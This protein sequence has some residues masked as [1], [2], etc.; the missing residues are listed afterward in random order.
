MI[1]I[2][3]PLMYFSGFNPR[4]SD[5]PVTNVAVKIDFEGFGSL[6]STTKY[7]GPRST[8]G[9][10]RVAIRQMYPSLDLN[11]YFYDRLYQFIETEKCSGDVWG[12]SPQGIESILNADVGGFNLNME[13][14]ITRTNSV[15]SDLLVSKIH[16]I[17]LDVENGQRLQNL[18]RYS[19]DLPFNATL[20]DSPPPP[21]RF[22]GVYD[23]FLRNSPT[24]VKAFSESSD[25]ADYPIDCEL[26]LN[27]VQT[28]ISGTS[29]FVRSWCM[30]CR[31][32][33]MGG[34]FPE[35]SSYVAPDKNCLLNFEGC[36]GF[37]Y[38]NPT[39]NLSLSRPT[40]VSGI[41]FSVSSDQV[42]DRLSVIPADAGIIALY[43]TFVLA[44]A[45]VIRGRLT[46]AIHRVVLE[47]VQD[48]Q[49]LAIY[50]QYIWMSRGGGRP[51]RGYDLILEE[52]LYLEMLDLL[53][54]PEELLRK[55]KKRQ[56]AYND[57]GVRV[58]LEPMPRW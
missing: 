9:A 41:Y 40:N 50:V 43:T 30:G 2:F 18:V 21:A 12:I 49:S 13:I 55:T 11:D 14:A 37:D 17:N 39:S 34:N 54:S 57:Y 56:E 23:P 58:D 31:S 10:Q 48:P 47:E 4:L 26:N 24:D 19:L 45:S 1:I 46:G 22:G 6:Y 33:F 36:E 38:T 53:R 5:N 44:L 7:V 52:Q 51:D 29:Q 25:F 8:E 15:A 32:L 35:S 27:I 3:F 16:H 28:N 20:A 42:P